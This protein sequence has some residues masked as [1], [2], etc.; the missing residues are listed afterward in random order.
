MIS[1]TLTKLL[2]S[3]N[4]FLDDSPQH[5]PGICDNPE[6]FVSWKEVEYCLNNPHFYDIQFIDK[7]TNDYISFPM[8]DRVWSPPT[9]EVE[10]IC[11]A[12][13]AGHACIINNFEWIKG[14]QELLNEIECIFTN[15]TAA[16]HV[17]CG[18]ENSKSF[19]IH[20]DHAHNF[21]LQ[22][23]GETHWKVYNNRQ[24]ELI[25][26]DVDPKESDLDCVIDVMLQPGDMLF[27]PE[28]CYHQAQ[29]KQKRLSI[30]IPMMS[31]PSMQRPKRKYYEI[32]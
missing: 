14:K 4:W 2:S 24:S 9:P 18:L 17:Y 25:S 21:I 6:E 11:N 26:A 8:Y 29:P 22:V 20:R 27:I 5:F 32:N 30:S 15:I 10:D 1:S 3:K 23:D 13:K 7:K 19:P 31:V 28:R 16:F 12:F